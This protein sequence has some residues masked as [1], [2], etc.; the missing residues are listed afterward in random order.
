MTVTG[1]S[2]DRFFKIDEVPRYTEVCPF[3]A[4]TLH[5]TG[6]PERT[7]KDGF[8]GAKCRLCQRYFKI[9]KE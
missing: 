4:N 3:D 1:K 5:F 2:K 7:L 8:Y 6:D 9:P